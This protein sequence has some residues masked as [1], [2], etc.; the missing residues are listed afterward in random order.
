MTIDVLA[1]FLELAELASPSG[2]EHRVA[3]RVREFARSRGLEVREDAAAERI[4]GSTGNILLTLPATAGGVPLLFCAHLDTV[5]V[6]GPISARIADGMVRSDGRTILGADDKAAVAAMLA[7]LDR[8]LEEKRPH[9]GLEFLFT[10]MEEVG[11]RGAKAFDR[12]EL[13]A[14]CGFV[15]DHAGPLGT[16]VQSAP[17]GFLA[18]LEFEG[19]AAHAGIAPED[20][21]SAIEAAA[22]TVSD[23]SLGKL[24]DGSTLNIGLI[25]GGTVHNVVAERCRLTADIRARTHP[26]AEAL[27]AEVLATSQLQAARADCLIS[28][29][30]EEKYRAYEFA[31]DDLAVRL[32]R[33]ALDDLG[34][35]P[36]LVTGGGGADASIFNLRGLPCL[37]LGNGMRD[38]HTTHEQIAIA[39]LRASVELTLGLIARACDRGEEGG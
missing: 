35:V 23:L 12:G 18:E 2:E 14:E 33:S 20:G 15:Y 32:A 24:A 10:P 4:G 5:P 28:S 30:V 19:R 11:C 8:L 26:R 38:I 21:R 29:A 1:L 25:G 39:D 13:E 6:E 27:L 9:A 34:I 16:M 31:D 37:N 22:R 17:S 3:E 7:A 36:E